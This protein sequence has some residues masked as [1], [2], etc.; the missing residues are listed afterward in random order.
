MGILDALFGPKVNFK[1]LK[2][3]GAII[4]DVRTA[5]EYREGHIKGSL[6]IPLDRLSAEVEKLG[7]KNAPI[8]TCCRSG[9]RSGSALGILKQAGIE[10]YNGGPWN[11]LESQIK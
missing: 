5:A 2:N 6:N 7:K 3:K 4:V 9:A 1:E 8:I 10:C 11:V